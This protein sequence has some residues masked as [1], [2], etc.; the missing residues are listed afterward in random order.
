MLLWIILGICWGVILCAAI[1]LFRLA[2]Y[3][4]R[5]MRNLA[6]RPRRSEDQAA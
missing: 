6:Q 3:A 5:K 2:G 1:C 4:D